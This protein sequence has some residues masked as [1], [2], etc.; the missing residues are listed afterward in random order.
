MRPLEGNYGVTLTVALLALIPFIVITT[1]YQFYRTQ[2]TFD[3]GASATDVEVIFGL[4]TAGYAF[5]ALLAGDLIQRFAQR[6]LFFFCEGMFVVGSVLAATAPHVPQFGVG[7]AIEG[8]ATGLLL[9][10]ALP[11]VIRNFPPERLPFT[12]AFIDLG[13]FGAVAVGPLVGGALGATHAWRW[14]YAALAAIGL[15][16]LVTA[17]LTL[18]RTKPQNPGQRF[19]REGVLLGFL[20]TALPFFAASNLTMQGLLSAWFLVPFTLGA[21]FFLALLFAEEN[22]AGALRRPAHLDERFP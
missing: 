19:D 20:G 16:T 6:S 12:A 1:A 9:V 5:G 15:V 10:V 8:L 18:P 17:T 2:I 3:I 4:A 14:L 13:F 22:C 21:L 11:P 7:V